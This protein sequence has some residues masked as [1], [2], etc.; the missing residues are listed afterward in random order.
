[1]EPPKK[2]M[3]L[4]LVVLTSVAVYLVFKDFLYSIMVGFTF[5]ALNTFIGNDS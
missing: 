5:G 1:M 3:D 2:K 4:L